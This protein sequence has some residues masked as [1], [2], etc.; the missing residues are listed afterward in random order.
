MINAASV[1]FAW[2][3]SIAIILATL[4][5]CLDVSLRNLFSFPINGVSEIVGFGIVS[6]VFLQIGITI[7][8]NR[9]ISAE[10]FSTIFQKIS[11]NFSH[12]LNILFFSAALMVF[13]LISVYFWND[14][15][16]AFVGDE[17]TGAIGAF[18]IPTWPFKL[19]NSIATIIIIFEI[20]RIVIILY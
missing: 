16:K 10:I 14:F 8:R 11:P 17:F 20:I 13:Y 2:A 1:L 12:L 7:R 9:L 18:Q 19:V 15:H 5:I 6:V 3:A 4:L